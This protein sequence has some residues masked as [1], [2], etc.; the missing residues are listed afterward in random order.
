MS[1]QIV[2]CGHSNDELLSVEQAQNALLDNVNRVTEIKQK[3]LLESLGQVLAADVASLIDVPG[4]DNSAMDGYAIAIGDNPV[5][6]LRF[7]VSQRI[8]AGAIGESLESGCAARI[9]TGAPI[10]QGTDAVVMQ[11]EV[12][13]SD[14]DI[15]INRLIN[16]GENI[17]PQGNDI[18]RN[19]IILPAGQLLG[20]Q[21]IALAA[22]VG[23]ATLPVY[24]K[25]RVGV[26]FT[27][28]E[29]VQPG[30]PLKDGQIYNSNRYAITSLLTNLGCEIQ[31]LGNVPDTLNA[32]CKALEL[33]AHDCDLIMTTGGVSVGEED[34]VKPAVAKLGSLSLWRIA[35]KPGKPLAFGAVG[36]TPFVGLP[37]NPVSAFVTFLL[38]AR[39]LILK[40][41]GINDFFPRTTQVRTDFD[42]H[43]C[44]SRREFVRVR[45][46]TAGTEPIASLFPK[47]GSDVLS[48]MAWADG[49]VVINE[50]QTFSKGEWVTFI[51][52]C[53][54]LT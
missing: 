35:M 45:V 17:R 38:F 22:S 32:T 21:H 30:T 20:P 50:E 3:T 10:P 12:Q 7:K 14:N 16:S 2:S 9:F 33:L 19:D 53:G 52:F 28:D 29:L 31:D 26:F 51:P 25:L 1:S 44:K 40:I 5:L 13:V 27:G 47:Q 36:E 49:L 41:Q 15:E 46:D 4:F 6:P 37:G 11:E 48:S 34:H 23:L 39:P 8:P 24:R 54:V 18:A 43:R 42:W